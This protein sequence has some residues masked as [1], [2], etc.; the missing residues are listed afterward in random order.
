MSSIQASAIDL[1]GANSSKAPA[2]VKASIDF[3]PPNLI[4]TFFVRSNK[5]LN[6]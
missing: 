5:S 6:E 4:F 2:L 1:E 3:L